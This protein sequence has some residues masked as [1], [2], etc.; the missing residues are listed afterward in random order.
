MWKDTKRARL[1]EGRNDWNMKLRRI[2]AIWAAKLTEMICV[3]IFHR[4]GATWAGRIALLICPSILQELAGEVRMAVF[5]VCGT[6]GKTTVNNLLSAALEAEG[7]E[8]ICN[9]SGSNMLNGVAAA[10]VLKARGNGKLSADYAC[11]EMDEAATRVIFEH[12][13]PDYMILTNLFRDQLDR[14]G[15]I[16]I[17]MDILKNVMQSAPGMK[18]IVNGDDPLSACLAMDSGND[19]VTYGISECVNRDNNSGEI[20]EGRFCRRCGAELS[21]R[22]YHYGQLGDYACLECGFQRPHIRYLGQD[23]ELEKEIALTVEGERLRSSQKGFYNVYNILAVYAAIQAGGVKPEHFR[24]TLADFRP[25]NGRMEEFWLG[26]TKIWLNLAKNPTGF[27]QNIDVMIKDPHPK[28]LVVVINDNAQDGAD[29]S[30]LWDVDF[31]R[32][33]GR[34]IRTVI[35]SG[36]RCQDLLLR[37]KYAGMRSELEPDVEKAVCSCVGKDSRNLYVLVNYTAL[38][39]TRNLL[40]RICRK[41]DQ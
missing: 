27:N 19:F 24:E 23:I 18:V 17:T 31:E 20:R 1:N 36:I 26:D 2:T 8:I 7:Y 5:A 34:G 25:G 40:Q 13:Q 16:D 14:Y 3:R 10:F 41:T 29:V 11:I 39:D 33:K 35:A 9:R 22:F 32:L 15:E 12:F 28:E 4:Q 6:N 21:Y 37:L 30:W 38:S